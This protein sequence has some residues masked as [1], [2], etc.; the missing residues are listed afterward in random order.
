MSHKYTVEFRIYGKSLDPAAVTADLGL[1]P[2]RTVNPGTRRADGRLLEGL[3]AFDGDPSE[4]FSGSLE[5]AL[6]FV[7]DLLHPLKERILA[8][9][10]SAHLV[11]WCGHFQSSFDG[12]YTLSAAVLG[13]LSDF[14]V[15]FTVDNYFSE[16]EA[17]AE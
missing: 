9:R 7:L 6:R 14:G 8:Y 16:S 1:E 15:E 12:G 13:Q 4:A 5:E 10:T 3:W 11:W 2:C 17:T